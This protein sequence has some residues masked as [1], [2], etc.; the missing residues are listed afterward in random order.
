MDRLSIALC[1]TDLDVGGAERSL[2]EIATRLDRGRFEPTVYCLGPRPACEDAS[3]VPPLEAAGIEVHCLG[4]RGASD[5]LGVLG[6][7]TGLLRR[8]S[9]HVVQ[10][11]LFHANLIGRIAAYRAGIRPVV[12]GIRVA[13][14][15]ARWHLWADRLTS[16]MVDRYVCVSHSVAEFSQSVGGLPAGKLT[17]IPNGVDVAKYPA[18]RQ[19]DLQQFGLPAGRRAITTIGRLEHQKGLDWLLDAAPSV[20]NRLPGYDLLLVGD[21]PERAKL[22]ALARSSATA[23]RV[24]FAGWRPD[25][26]EILAASDL[27]VLP[28]RWEGMPN[29]VLQ[30][31]ATRLPVVA[32]D[33]E[34]V[35]ETLGP[36]AEGQAVSFGDTSGLVNAITRLL[37]DAEL[38]SGVGKA[39]RQRV[40]EHFAWERIVAAYQDLWR[41]LREYQ[42]CPP[43]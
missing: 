20:L 24:H 21:G 43:R 7:L 37:T 18:A 1:I 12:C 32:S 13:E 10:T 38:R 4:A 22:E 34:G 27:L 19:A 29:V 28:S 15:Q 42:R 16:R 6:K 2:V 17:V 23:D 25:V 14:R 40:A 3:C 26:R 9:P 31:M 35:R 39:N 11:F 33:V 41:G 8:Q 5:F 30:A 36:L